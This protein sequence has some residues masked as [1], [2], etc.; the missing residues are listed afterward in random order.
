MPAMNMALPWKPLTRADYNDLE[1]KVNAGIQ[2]GDLPQIV[3]AYTSAL[4]NW[5][6]GGS[7][8]GFEPVRL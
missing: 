4:N 1:D 8:C 2:S 3:Q 5:D 7:G 6:T